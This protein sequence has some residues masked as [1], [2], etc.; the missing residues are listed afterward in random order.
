S[1]EVAGESYYPE[2]IKQ[3][4]RDNSDSAV[5]AGSGGQEL[6]LDAVLVA[7]PT[8]PFDQNAVAVYVDGN[9]VGY[10][11]RGDAPTYHRA[12]AEAAAAGRLLTFT[13]RQWAR[14]DRDGVRARVTLRLPEPGGLMPPVGYLPTVPHAVL[15]VGSAIQ[16]AKEDEHMEVLARHVIPDHGHSVAATLHVVEEARSRSTIDI[17]EVR[18]RGQ[19]VGVLSPTQTANLRPL[20]DHLAAVGKVAAVRAE[21]VGNT[22]KADVVIFAQKANMVPRSWLDT[23][24]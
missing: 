12:I 18:L 6:R 14:I 3:L 22:T 9:H 1:F 7:A 13:S 2:G 19:R 4:F 15:P 16:V 10:L 21:V 20:V 23:H 11:E 8:N 5:M 17:M 24:G